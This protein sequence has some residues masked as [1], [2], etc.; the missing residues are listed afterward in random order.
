MSNSKT[1]LQ[2]EL[3]LLSSFKL[4]EQEAYLN[5]VRTHA[6]LVSEFEKLFKQHGISQP[7]F[8]V[9]K[10]VARDIEQG[11]PSQSL[12]QYMIAK[13]P[14]ITRL[15]DRLAK[16]GL[17]SRERG[18]QDRRVVSVKIT[19]R[20]LQKIKD[21]DPEVRILHKQQL[22]HMSTEK[23]QLLSTLLVKARHL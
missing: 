7:L 2:A 14:D 1:S 13:D 20:G 9:L 5:L 17:V 18:T 8:N 21:L 11:C 4:A 6:I 10:A 19:T 12:A 15:V 3:N 22:G 23:L 16:L